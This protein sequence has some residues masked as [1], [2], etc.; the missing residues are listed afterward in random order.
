MLSTYLYTVYIDTY[1][2][3]CTYIY[4][5]TYEENVKK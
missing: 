2:N 5:H 3:L 4:V 1:I